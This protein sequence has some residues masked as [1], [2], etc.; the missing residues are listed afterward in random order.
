M[1]QGGQAVIPRHARFIAIV[2]VRREKLGMVKRT[3][4]EID[5]IAGD[6]LIKQRRT[7]GAAKAAIDMLGTAKARRRAARPGDRFARRCDKRDED[8]AD[9]LLAHAAMADMRVVEHFR[10]VIAHGAAL[11]AAADFHCIALH[12]LPPLGGQSAVSWSGCWLEW[13]PAMKSRHSS[14]TSLRT[15]RLVRSSKKGCLSSRLTWISGAATVGSSNVPM[16][17]SSPKRVS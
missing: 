4:G 10:G 13:M 11:A 5:P 3:N 14:L 15:G 8:I 17:S 1:R 7:T 12:Q 6:V 16:A 2:H 9:G